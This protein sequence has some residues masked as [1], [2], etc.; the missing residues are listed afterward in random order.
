MT[1]WLCQMVCE[2]QLQLAQNLT[3]VFPLETL[4]NSRG[5]GLAKLKDGDYRLPLDNRLKISPS[6][7]LITF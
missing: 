7:L 1:Y 6:N 5:Q 3:E 2:K 4:A